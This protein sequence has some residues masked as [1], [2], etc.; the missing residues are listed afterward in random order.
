MDAILLLIALSSSTIG[1]ITG[2]G[3]GVIIK[4]VVDALGLLSV[5]TASFLSGGTVLSMSTVT[6]LK[7]RRAGIKIDLAYTTYLALGAAVGGIAGKK[8][9]DVM[10]TDGTND[11]AV[12][13]TQSTLLLLLT[14][15]V[16]F[17]MIKKEKIQTYQ[18][19]NKVGILAVGLMLGILS[20]FLGIGGGPINLVA[21]YML[22][23]MDSKTAA[24]NSLYVIF[25]SQITS[26][27]FSI[28][29]GE[30]PFF[31]PANLIVMVIGGVGGGIAG[32]EILKKI[33]NRKAETVFRFLLIVII[34][35]C[36]FNIWRCF[37]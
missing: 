27:C 34:F 8:I 10:R 5:S 1:S 24:L 15:L 4:P 14:V 16:F 3:G 36:G 9:F 20:S 13:F 30:I 17:Y 26:L 21:L 29:G 23:S 31:M 37:I 22:F 11:L 33:A 28:L 35:I 32:S 25:C 18:V 2:I 7:S 12:K 6:L 19:K